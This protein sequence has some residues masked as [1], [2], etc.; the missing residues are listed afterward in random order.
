[1][2]FEENP[3]ENRVLATWI[4]DINASEYDS[5][6]ALVLLGIHSK[7]V[8]KNLLKTWWGCNLENVARACQPGVV[9]GGEGLCGRRGPTSGRGHED[10][11]GIV[12]VIDSSTQVPQMTTLF[13]KV[14][15]EI[16]VDEL[17][18]LIDWNNRMLEQVIR[19]HVASGGS[20]LI[21]W[22]RGS[23]ASRRHSLGEGR[24][25]SRNRAAGV[26]EVVREHLNDLV[27]SIFNVTHKNNY[28]SFMIAKVTKLYK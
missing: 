7:K 27:D 12:T 11:V 3:A 26:L 18:T 6:N 22:D 14:S 28:S 8:F 24:A 2:N 19:P 10:A 15:R 4:D 23:H 16:T 9:I 17:Q 5:I 13:Q 21:P 25:V 1:M 20:I